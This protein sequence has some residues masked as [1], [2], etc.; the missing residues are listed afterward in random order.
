MNPLLIDRLKEYND[1]PLIAPNGKAEGLCLYIRALKDHPG[2]AKRLNEIYKHPV[3]DERGKLQGLNSIIE[4]LR[5]AM[6]AFR[7]N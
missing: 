3:I 2:L 7:I 1:K 5:K 6:Q 4:E